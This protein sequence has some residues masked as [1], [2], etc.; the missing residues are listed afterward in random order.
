MKERIF[1]ERHYFIFI[2]VSFLLVLFMPVASVSDTNGNGVPAEFIQI[3]TF[4]SNLEQEGDKKIPYYI[5]ESHISDNTRVLDFGCGKCEFFDR[6]KGKFN[7]LKLVGYDIDKYYLD[8]GKKK[9]YEVYSSL[10]KIKGKFDCVICE[11]VIEHLTAEQARFF[12]KQS[13]EFLNSGGKLI[14]STLN[15]NEFY[16][17]RDIWNDPSH[18]RLYSLNA[19]NEI[20]KQNNLKL[21]NVNRYNGRINPLKILVNLLFFMSVYTGITLV[22]EKV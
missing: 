12:F 15:A 19:L 3:E 4:H 18:I 14:I 10:D 1:K 20:A 8:L 17:L 11:Q 2:V 9:G 21:I 22:F 6:V 7:N 13:S 5:T 16:N